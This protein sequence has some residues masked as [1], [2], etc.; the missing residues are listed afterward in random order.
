MSDFFKD[1]VHGLNRKYGYVIFGRNISFSPASS[2]FSSFEGAARFKNKQQIVL[3]K[4]R[5]PMAINNP[6]CIYKKSRDKP[7]KNVV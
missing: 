4:M 2:L 7:N 5:A 1:I 6:N 3:F